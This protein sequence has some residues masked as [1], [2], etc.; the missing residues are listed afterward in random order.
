M[1]HGTT[2]AS[3]IAG[4]GDDRRGVVGLAPDARILP[5]RVLDDENRYDDAMI[6]ARGYVGRWTTAPA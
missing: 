1:G 6:V 3:L 2:V 5:V 4:R